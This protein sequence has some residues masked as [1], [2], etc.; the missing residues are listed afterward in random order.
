MTSAKSSRR[1]FL[2]ASTGLAG[3]AAGFTTAQ[4]QLAHALPVTGADA[5]PFFGVHQAGITSP[6]QDALY[7]AAFD[8]GTEKREDLITLLQNWT[9][10]AARL[11]AGLPAEPGDQD[12]QAPGLD[13][14]EAV[15]LNPSRLTITFGFGPELFTLD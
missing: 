4:A 13:T 3:A 2:A 8:L 15:G 11:T 6:M 7:F 9:N 1:G 12:G 14:G 10:A 5:E